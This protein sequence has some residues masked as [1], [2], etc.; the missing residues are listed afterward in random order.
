MSEDFIMVDVKTLDAEILKLK[1]R[2]GEHLHRT[3]SFVRV[4]P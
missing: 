1:G 2:L 3:D 4:K